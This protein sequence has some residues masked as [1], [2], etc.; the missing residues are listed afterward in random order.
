M[1]MKTIRN[2]PASRWGEAFPLGNGFMGAMVYGKVG[3]EQI[4]LS[5]LTFFSGNQSEENNQ[6]QAVRAFQKMRTE[7]VAENFAAMTETASQI[8]G[9]RKNYGTNLPVGKLL[10]KTN[11][12]PKA[13]S[14]Y[15]RELDLCHGIAS[16]G[17]E[18]KN[19][20]E[21][22]I[23]MKSSCYTSHVH[24]VMVYRMKGK[25]RDLAASISFTS[26]RDCENGRY[27][28]CEGFFECQALEQ[29]HSDGTTGVCLAGGFSVI[30]DGIISVDAEGVH[31]TK[32]A[33]VLIYLAMTT[34]FGRESEQFSGER[35]VKKR[36]KRAEEIGYQELTKEHKKDMA[37]LFERSTLSILGVDKW[38]G[39]LAKMYQMGRYLLYSSSREDSRLPTHLQGIWN[40]NVA[41]RIGWTCDM[42][43]D[44]NTQMNYWPAEVTGLS[45]MTKPLFHWLTKSVVPSGRK[46]AKETYGYPGFVA[47]LVSNAWG[48]AAPYWAQSLAPCPACGIWILTHMWE[49]YCYSKDREYLEKEAFWVIEEATKFFEAYVFETTG[50][51][52]SSGPSIS[53]ENSFISDGRVYHNSVGCTFE[54]LMIRE[55]FMIYKEACQVLKKDGTL[56]K[57]V[58]EKLPKLLPYRILENG[59]I[60]EWAHDFEAA[61]LQHRH[62]SHLLGVFPFAQ[63][64]PA[65]KELAT[66]A[67]QTMEQKLQP[68]ENWEDTG[69]A[70]SMLMLYETRLLQPKRAYGHIQAM[71]EN[72]LEPNGMIIHPPTRGAAAFDNVYELDGNTGLTTCIAEMLLQS[73]QEY[74]HILPCLPAEW[75]QGEVTGLRARG[76]LVIDI[77]WRTDKVEVVIKGN[78]SGLYKL[79]YQEQERKIELLEHQRVQISFRKR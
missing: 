59:T 70:R 43:L 36:L 78:E 13:I 69:W 60:A 71:L 49:H 39:Y 30:S 54:I 6:P 31:I 27:E 26:F 48:F 10:I 75:E 57:R 22:V 33:E 56:L 34:D 72:L 76:N 35:I 58:Q 21:Q 77:C 45:E 73:H 23:E 55:L 15:A 16:L 1:H 51:Y 62:T 53:P 28:G 14:H 2:T 3:E 29:I 7:A 64:T 67:G 5:E 65:Q 37:G 12:N 52:L 40:D 66:A 50:G 18:Y 20:D 47:E 42:H 41:C 38:T 44:V 4:D 25:E 19:A 61:D 68:Q 74:I 46:T 9:V 17:Y 63:I 79:R 24:Q 8:I 11:Q 32:A